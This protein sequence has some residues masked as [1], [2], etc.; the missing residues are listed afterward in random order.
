MGDQE[1]WISQSGGF[2]ELSESDQEEARQ[3]TLTGKP[4][5][6]T[7]DV[8]GCVDYAQEK[9]R[10]RNEEIASF[11]IK[12]VSYLVKNLSLKQPLGLLYAEVE[13]VDCNSLKL[14]RQGKLI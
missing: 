3:A 11:V 4:A 10:E 9:Q 1:G 14:R 7:F 12:L 6:H 13:V 5:K 8:E 2:S